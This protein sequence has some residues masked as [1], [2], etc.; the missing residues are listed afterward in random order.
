MQKLYFGHLQQRIHTRERMRWLR[1]LLRPQN[2]RKSVTY[3]TLIVFMLR[4]YVDE[5]KWCINSEWAALGSAL[6]NVLLASCVHHLYLCWRK[7]FWA[8]A[9]IRMMWC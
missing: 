6:L 2:H 5:L 1:K 8:Y 9:V 4:L 3:S 7:T